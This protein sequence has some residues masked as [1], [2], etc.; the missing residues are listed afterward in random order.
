MPHES[1]QF[2]KILPDHFIFKESITKIAKIQKKYKYTL[3]GKAKF[4]CNGCKRQWTSSRSI[5]IF[6]AKFLKE[7][8]DL[9]RKGNINKIIYDTLTFGQ[10]CNIC[11]HQVPPNWY[12]DEIW[13]LIQKLE[14]LIYMRNSPK[15]PIKTTNDSQQREADPKK[16]HDSSRCEACKLNECIEDDSKRIVNKHT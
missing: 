16:N 10:L 1:Y 14:N 11:E 3:K 9:S 4:Q 6:E 2:H 13:R 15:K 5:I 8:I 12:E 7:L